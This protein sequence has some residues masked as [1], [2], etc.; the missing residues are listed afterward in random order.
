[1]RIWTHIAW[2][3]TGKQDL[4]KAYNACI[5]QHSDEDWVAFIDH[6]AMFT[7]SDWYLQLQEIIKMNPNCKGICSRV[8]R[9]ATPEQMV[10]GIDPNNFDYAYHRKVGKYLGQ[11]YKNESTLLTQPGHMSGVFFALHVG[12]IK[13][14]GGCVETG[15]M[16]QVDHRTM[17]RVR[18]AGYEFRIADGIYIFHW[19]RHDSPYSHSKLAMVQLSELHFNTL[20][21]N[22]RK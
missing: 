2:D 1:M 13:S 17:D 7:T 21:L 18:N 6:D 16:L 5:S 10:L 9:M 3:H 11:K 12:T 22:G 14:L 4:G 20:R 19:Y 8:N 15:E